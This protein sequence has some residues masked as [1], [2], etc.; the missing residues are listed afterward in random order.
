MQIF[1]KAV[2]LLIITLV[3]IQVSAQSSYSEQLSK[4]GRVLTLVNSLYVDTVDQ[5]ELVEDAIVSMLQELDPHSIYIS[6]DEVKRMNEPLQGAFEGIGI[7]FNI[8]KDT[9]MVVATIPGGPSEKLG[10]MAGDRIIE[11]D[12]KEIAGIGLSNT[13]VRDMLRGEKGT[14]V[15]VKILRRGEDELLDFTI[16]RDEIPIYSVNAGYVVDDE[17]GY[18]KLNRFSKTTDEELNEVFDEFDAAGVEDIILDLSDNGGGYM[19]KAI[20]LADQ[21]LERNE[22]I[23]YTEGENSPKREYKASDDGRYDDA[24]VVVLVNE[25]SASAS[26][27]VSGAIQDWD[28]GVVVG[29]RSFGK[30]LVQR[31]FPLPDSSM[32]RLTVARYYTPAG[33]CIQK[34]YK[35]GSEDYGHELIDRYNEGELTNSDSIHFPDSLLYRTLRKERNVY[36]GGGIMPDVFIPLDTTQVSDYHGELMRKGL[37]FSFAVQYVD[38]NRDMLNNKFEEFEKYESEFEV[39]DDIIAELDKFANEKQEM[40]ES[41]DDMDSDQLKRLKIHLKSLVASDLWETNEFYQVNNKINP[42]FLKAVE[43]LRNPE[44]YDA[45][46]KK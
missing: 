21:F 38:K 43:L 32:I 17:I 5:E 29:R 8:M 44:K 2:I 3:G 41:M 24:R 37:I 30:G 9:L 36:G 16:V 23:V 11:V 4:F 20:W 46:I 28:R 33:R 12:G 40:K 34:P 42:S 31:P 27:I 25:S 35:E 26:E 1:R 45:I 7:Q 18:V 14:E 13:D 10:I 22:M 19:D 15:D 6:K 39:T